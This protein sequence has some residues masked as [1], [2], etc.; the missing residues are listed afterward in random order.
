MSLCFPNLSFEFNKTDYIV[1]FGNGSE[2]YFLG[3]DDGKRAEKILGLEISSIYFNEASEIDYSSVQIGLSRLAEKNGLKKKAYFD[4]NPPTKSHWSYY[5]FMKKLNPIDD[6]PVPNPQ[7]YAALK[8]NPHQNIENLDPEY[9]ALLETMP[10][11]EKMRFLHGEF[12]DHSSGVAYYSFNEERHV[13]EV[14]R[15]PG[16]LAIGMD[17]NY[18]FFCATI[19]QYIN[20][21][22]IFLDEVCLENADTYKMCDELKKRGYGGGIIYPDHSGIARRTSGKS[23]FDILRENGFQI[24]SVANPLQVDRVNNMNRLFSADGIIASPKCKRLRNDWQK[25]TWKDNKLDQTGHNKMLTH[26]SDAASYWTWRV[27]PINGLI[28]KAT[29]QPR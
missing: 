13:K 3:L 19:G 9:L 8:M 22:F 4:F 2:I 15:Q 29:S 5:L 16:T 24:Q 10:E 28:L 6:V 12:Q 17:F 11:K 20:N 7:D 25:V 18:F 21:K 27:D 26:I 1:R 14:Q 23:D